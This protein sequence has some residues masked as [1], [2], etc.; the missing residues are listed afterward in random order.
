MMERAWWEVDDKIVSTVRK[1]RK[2]NAEAV[3]TFY[4]LCSSGTLVSQRLLSTFKVEL[5]TSTNLI[6]K[7]KFERSIHKFLH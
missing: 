1:L 2:M 4:F 3:F 5:P 6:Y 7:I